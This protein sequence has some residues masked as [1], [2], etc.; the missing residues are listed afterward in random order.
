MNE[1]PKQSD[2]AFCA[3]EIDLGRETLEV[4]FLFGRFPLVNNVTER[5][6]MRAVERSGNRMTQRHVF[7]VVD[8]H[9]CPGNGL[10]RQ[11]LQS[12]CAT[13]CENRNRTTNATKHTTSLASDSR[14]VNQSMAMAAATLQS[15]VCCQSAA[16]QGNRPSLAV[17]LRGRGHSIRAF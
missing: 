16:L 14:R 11:P 2:R 15:G 6:G 9:C 4:R 8:D 1:R 3:D 17:G 10:Q 13:K 12:N 7:R 5:T